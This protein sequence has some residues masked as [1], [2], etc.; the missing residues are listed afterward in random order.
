MASIRLNFAPALSR[1]LFAIVRDNLENY[2][3]DDNSLPLTARQETK[4]Q[5]EL[6]EEVVGYCIKDF[7]E[8]HP[9]AYREV[10]E[11]AQTANVFDLGR[12]ALSDR[13]TEIVY[14]EWRRQRQRYDSS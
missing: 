10:R 8:K 4:G 12:S 6:R 14:R 7:Q 3:L 2:H 1:T 13:I 9:E 5:Q 11:Q